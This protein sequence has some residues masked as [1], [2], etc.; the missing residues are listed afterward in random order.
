MVE[1]AFTV[2]PE[3]LLAALMGDVYTI[4]GVAR[5]RALRR[6]VAWGL[7]KPLLR[8]CQAMAE[9]DRVVAA[10]GFPMG[11][12]WLA[13][14]WFARDIHVRGQENIP[15][16]APLVVVSNHPGGIDSPSLSAA[17]GRKDLKIIASN[18][19]LLKRLPNISQHLIF[20]ADDTATRMTV[21]RETIRHLETGGALLLFPTGLIDPDPG[22]MPGAQEALRGWSGSVEIFLR[23]VPEARLLPAV[24]S[25]VLHP[26]VFRHPL[27]L[28][29]RER[30]KRQRMAE[31]LQFVEQLLRPNRLRLEPRVSFG[32]PRTLAELEAAG[33]TRLREAITAIERSLIAEHIAAY[34][35]R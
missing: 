5:M 24:A 31:L 27:A 30:W 11:A 6:L 26:A 35:G 23:K 34:Y 10:E 32:P 8:F 33:S 28:L 29:H 12:R 4:A 16:D 2:D 9:T 18:A 25:D 1:S 15:P 17:L 21:I 13:T 19:P 7:R 14:N 20:I 22:W 3:T